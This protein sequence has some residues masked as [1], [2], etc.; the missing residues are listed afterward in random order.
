MFLGVR[1]DM[2]DYDYPK[3]LKVNES[4]RSK[5]LVIYVAVKVLS[6]A[7]VTQC[8]NSL[9]MAWQLTEAFSSTHR[10][11]LVHRQYEHTQGI[12]MDFG[13]SRLN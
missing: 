8:C 13:Y 5:S 1:L 10:Y 7:P 12:R 11:C 2:M 3:L 9:P 4:H 6:M